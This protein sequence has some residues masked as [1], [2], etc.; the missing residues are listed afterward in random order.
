MNYVC[1][2]GR[3]GKDA[4]TRILENGTVVSNTTLATNKKYKNKLGELIEDTQWH[5]VV[6]WGKVGEYLK[7][8]QLVSLTGELQHREWEKNGEKRYFTEVVARDVNIL[9]RGKE[10]RQLEEND[11]PF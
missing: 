7:K 1:L 5:S 10:E 6:V 3:I 8:G 2:V 9:Q 11:I 4:E